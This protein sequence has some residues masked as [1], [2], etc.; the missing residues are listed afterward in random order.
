ME[1]VG[2]ECFEQ[3]PMSQ[4]NSNMNFSPRGLPWSQN[5]VKCPFQN[6]AKHDTYKKKNVKNVKIAPCLN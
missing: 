1:I 5:N 6:I 4:E 2:N 3:L